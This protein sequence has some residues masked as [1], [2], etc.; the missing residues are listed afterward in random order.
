MPNASN[1]NMLVDLTAAASSASVASQKKRPG[2]RAND[3][4]HPPN[5]RA[6]QDDQASETS[7]DKKE[8]LKLLLQAASSSCVQKTYSLPPDYQAGP[9]D[10]LFGGERKDAKLLKEDKDSSKEDLAF[11]K[12]SGNRAFTALCGTYKHRFTGDDAVK[13]GKEKRAIL[14]EIMSRVGR[15]GGRFIQKQQRGAA[16]A[17]KEQ[18]WL[19]LSPE[20]VRQSIYRT[21]Y[22]KDKDDELESVELIKEKEKLEAPKNRKK[23][24]RGSSQRPASVPMIPVGAAMATAAR[25]RF[26]HPPSPPPAPRTFAPPAAMMAS[27]ALPPASAAALPG[28]EDVLLLCD[29]ESCSA[30]TLVPKHNG[31]T[32]LQELVSEEAME[33]LKQQEQDR[34]VREKVALQHHYLYGSRSGEAP[35]VPLEPPPNEEVSVISVALTKHIW[36]RGGR[37]LV[38]YRN[39]KITFES[40]A[41]TWREMPHHKSIEFTK[42][43]LLMK[44][45][46]LIQRQQRLAQQQEEQFMIA[47]AMAAAPAPLPKAQKESK[48]NGDV[49][50][51]VEK[52]D[53]MCG[54]VRGYDG[55]AIAAHGGNRK[56]RSLI[57]E[58]RLAFLRATEEADKDAL[59]LQVMKTVWKTGG[60]FLFQFDQGGP[61]RGLSYWR[62]ACDETVKELVRSAFGCEIYCTH[63]PLEWKSIMQESLVLAQL[64]HAKEQ[65]ECGCCYKLGQGL[66]AKQDD[67]IALGWLQ[68][69]ALQGHAE[70]QWELANCYEKGIGVPECDHDLAAHWYRRATL[71]FHSSSLG[72]GGG[73][74]LGARGIPPTSH[75]D[76]QQHLFSQQEATLPSRRHAYAMA[77]HGGRAMPVLQ[78]ARSIPAG[79]QIHVLPRFPSEYYK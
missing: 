58:S 57:V 3:D 27:A 46:E 63:S 34:A 30:I 47:A 21:F 23:R 43:L 25:G 38:Q 26:D 51:T 33:L 75:G 36:K 49:I 35:A 24:A 14:N 71:Q 56:F 11:L 22:A 60:R 16:A 19:Q 40:V 7:E 29:D 65:Y 10:V 66:V 5:K 70:A 13:T 74:S 76:H 37:Y 32:F 79:Q 53:V 55:I 50:Q 17:S 20:V 64:G 73:S 59:I 31:N 45:Q 1:S 28:E 18:R 67:K 78:Q 77:E 9:D 52:E 72:V 44:N 62:E 6:K 4:I 15:K 69:A 41:P 48:V 42:Q 8:K 61:F 54:A 68:K 12:K 39:E 2:L